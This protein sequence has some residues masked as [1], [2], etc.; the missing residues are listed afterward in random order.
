MSEL[1]NTFIDTYELHDES[2]LALGNAI[3][4]DILA[5]ANPD[6]WEDNLYLSF[7]QCAPEWEMLIS[8]GVAASPEA[9]KNRETQVGA[10]VVAQETDD[11]SFTERQQ[12]S[13]IGAEVWRTTST[14][15]LAIAA[16]KGDEASRAW[17]RSD[18]P[19][20]EEI[21]DEQFADLSASARR[22]VGDF[23]SFLA[24]SADNLIH[25]IGK[26]DIFVQRVEARGVSCTGMDHDAI[27]RRVVLDPE[28]RAQLLPTIDRLPSRAQELVIARHSIDLNYGQ[29]L[30]LEAPA[31]VI[32]ALHGVDP[33]VRD[34]FFLH[35]KLDIAG[36]LAH[37]EKNIVLGNWDLVAKDENGVPRRVPKVIDKEVYQDMQ[38]LEWALTTSDLG[39][40]VDRLHA[41]M[42]RRGLRLGF[43]VEALPEEEK[44]A[45]YALITL[46]GRQ[47]IHDADKFA[48]LREDFDR[49]APIVK[50]IL[51][52]HLNRHGID[53][54]AILHNYSPATLR[55]LAGHPDLGED[56][57]AVFAL[58]LHE[59]DWY[60]ISQGHHDETLDMAD[61]RELAIAINRNG[62]KGGLNFRFKA[63]V[64][65]TGEAML[66]PYKV[67]APLDDLDNLET[68]ADDAPL[69]GKKIL[70]VAMSGGA[71]GLHARAIA[72][73]TAQ[74][75][76]TETAG[77]LVVRKKE[78]MVS[79][80]KRKL[81]RTTKEIDRNTT[82]YGNWRF[83]EK[84]IVEESEHPPVFILN[85]QSRDVIQADLAEVV[86]ETGADI[87]IGVDPTGDSYN[88]SG[89][90]RKQPK[91]LAI[92][93]DHT[94]I[95]ALNAL[96]LPTYTLAFGLSSYVPYG[97]R[98]R[99][100]NN[101]AHRLPATTEDYEV[102]E[103]MY[104]RLG[105]AHGDQPNFTTT[106]LIMQEA[107]AGHYGLRPIDLPEHAA[108]SVENPWRVF[109]EVTRAAKEFI[110]LDAAT[111]RAMIEE[112]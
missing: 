78:R 77:I 50:T 74:K 80:E 29:L 79:G 67:A 22:T 100:G 89:E 23:E 86:R 33:K 71:G 45:G 21:T 68:F 99:L 83:A 101:G 39:D 72:E 93:Q 25:D 69:R 97:I 15:D 54:D 91:H 58:L 7:I 8:E 105:M 20:P 84:A 4:A 38:D 90:A 51:T 87:I 42:W 16:A 103:N 75:Y 6:E 96:D 48:R 26:S 73:M 46:A 10:V 59:A 110:L 98:D 70:F 66:V 24:L 18:P 53:D 11:S 37:N 55:A 47:R 35:A 109:H 14:V 36:V 85:S 52:D 60:R 76:N 5:N 3:P 30:Q 12:L 41:Y 34:M 102:L 44:L 28:L 31:K 112:N 111:H 61:L 106:S 62:F 65:E 19:R 40:E 9:Y 32:R 57:L 1:E 107:I 17:F 2:G 104:G 94:T 43:D 64:S 108:L 81:G 27:A 13:R 63:E 88:T 82:V 56:Y 49:Q 95:A 92:R